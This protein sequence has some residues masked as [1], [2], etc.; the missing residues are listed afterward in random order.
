MSTEFY[1]RNWRMPNSFNGSEDNNS[2]FSNYSMSFDGSSEYIDLTQHDLG[3]TNTISL[4]LNISSIT[5]AQ[6]VLGEPSNAF[7]QSI[8]IA[9]NIIYIKDV[10]NHYKSWD[11]STSSEFS[12]NNWHHF[13]IVRSGSTITFYID[14]VDQGSPD[15]SSG[16]FTANTKFRYLG[17]N[18]PTNTQLVN[19]KID[20]FC[21]FD[22]ALTQAQIT[23]LYGS[24]STGVG[25]PMA[26]TNGR[27]P[28]FYAPLGDYSAYNGTEY[29]VPNSAV[30]DFVFEF[31]SDSIEVSATPS[32]LSLPSTTVSS[33]GFSIS[34]WYYHNTIVNFDVVLQSTNANANNGFGVWQSTTNNGL[35]FWVG[36]YLQGDLYTTNNYFT[37]QK[38]YNITC[39]FEGGATHTSKIFI[40][41]VLNNSVSYT[42][43]RNIHSGENILIG[44]WPL[45]SRFFDG[46]ISNAQIFN[47][48]L[49]AT[50][51]NSVETLYNY[52]TPLSD[53]SGFT[54]LQGWWKLDASAT[55][56]G[57]W[58]IPDDSSN[59]NTGT[60]SGMT[61]ANLVQ[62]NLNILSPYS[63]YALD[64]DGTNDYIETSGP[65]FTTAFSFSCWFKTSNVSANQTIW[66]IA[67]GTTA[68]SFLRV[69]GTNY[70]L[71]IFDSTSAS[72]NVETT[73]SIPI[74]GNWHHACFT[75]DGTSNT[76]GIILYL[77]GSPV[78]QGTLLNSGYVSTNKNF[79][80]SYVGTQRYF[81]G[82][83]SNISVWNAALTS[84]QVTEIYNNGLPSNLNNHSAYS[85]LVGWWQL[86]E[87]SSFNTNWT[88][89]NEISTGPNGVSANMAEDDLVNG[90]GTSGNGLSSGMG[91]ADNIIGEAPY[92]TSNAL[93]YGMGADAKSTSVPS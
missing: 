13:G 46:Q 14:G 36:H 84:A 18:Y 82:S 64:F 35:N 22:Y 88:V 5:A 83:L 23:A 90:V 24:S 80:G 9:S 43:S 93:S 8:I 32:E 40:D 17:T 56:S 72:I 51:S 27:K 42:T 78:A 2:K 44:G 63:R 57:N 10:S 61:A 3:T 58:S 30:S 50:G 29:L 55:F 25:N 4:W 85:N 49:P 74:D 59:S 37:S 53:M 34:F 68:K 15:S 33:G 21:I 1:N 79:I 31:S 60:S 67:D 48:E 70:R 47:T 92:S 77:D 73:T 7:K 65:N 19:G 52:G 6:T 71:K 81:D 54:S 87:N 20:H 28:I 39:T 12:L 89:L 69:V 76:N 11:L 91:G 66:S 38:W 62:S 26:I 86:G 75:A 16:A 45:Y 41:G